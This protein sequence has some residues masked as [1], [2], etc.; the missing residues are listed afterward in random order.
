MK[1]NK[2]DLIKLK[3][4][5]TAKEANKKANYGMGENFFILYDRLRVNVQS[6]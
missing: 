4:F 5:G 2:W 1:I 3:N 6:I